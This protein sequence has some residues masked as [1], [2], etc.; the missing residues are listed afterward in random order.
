MLVAKET[1]KQE[2]IDL[3]EVLVLDYREAQES[4]LAHGSQYAYR[5]YVRSFICLVEGFSY[6]LRQLTIEEY[7]DK[8]TIM[9]Q[10]ILDEIISQKDLASLRETKGFLKIKDGVSLVTSLQTYALLHGAI[11]AIEEQNGWDEFKYIID[12]RHKLTHPKKASDL[13]ISVDDLT[14]L[15][16]AYEWW[17]RNVARLL[18]LVEYI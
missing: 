5:A 13:E 16:I 11:F 10:S 1:A 4:A 2:L 18:L 8:K 9:S 17:D 6:R 3:Y 14:C 12:I 15:D 7:E